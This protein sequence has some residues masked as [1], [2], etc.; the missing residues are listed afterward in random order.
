MQKYNFFCNFGHLAAILCEKSVLTD[1]KAVNLQ[2][3]S[4]R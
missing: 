1:K 3:L 4:F 2:N